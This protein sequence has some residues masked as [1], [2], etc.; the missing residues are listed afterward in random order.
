MTQRR[1]ASSIGDKSLDA[2]NPLPDTK[3]F[4]RNPR[5][6]KS[7]TNQI[8]QKVPVW[9]PFITTAGL[10][11]KGPTSLTNFRLLIHADHHLCAPHLRSG[12]FIFHQKLLAQHRI[13]S[14]IIPPLAAIHHLYTLLKSSN[15]LSK[16]SSAD[17][18]AFIFWLS[19]HKDYQ[20]LSQ[21]HRTVMNNRNIGGKFAT[22]SYTLLTEAR[23]R[24]MESEQATAG[25]KSISPQ[26]PSLSSVVQGTIE[27]M[28][29][30][31]VPTNH[32]LYGMGLRNAVREK[33]W[34]QGIDIWKR[35]KAEQKQ[36]PSPSV[37]MIAYSVECYVQ[38]G[39]V[40]EA[41]RLLG[42]ILENPVAVAQPRV[43]PE[44]VAEGG[45]PARNIIGSGGVGLETGSIN[46][47]AEN[48]KRQ[49]ESMQALIA[50]GQR[51][52]VSSSSSS[53]TAAS[54][55]VTSPDNNLEWK[56]VAYPALIEAICVGDK[57][58]DQDGATLASELAL[59]L[60]KHGYALERSRFRLLIRHIGES[61]SSEGAENFLKRW[62]E[63]SR[64]VARSR[65]LS[66]KPATEETDGIIS[67]VSTEAK[68]SHR[69]KTKRTVESTSRAL[70]EAG[71]QEIVKLA[72]AERDFERAHR[73][74][75]GMS[76]QRIPL[77]AKASEEL[78]VGLT[79]DQDF[80]SA[81][82][83][84]EKCLLDN[85]VPSIET[86]NKL[87][88]GL[89]RGDRLDESVAVFRNLTENYGVNPNI[90]TFRSL[91]NLTA[92]YGQLPMTQR[93]LTTLKTLGMKQDGELYRD[94]MRCYVR[95]ENLKGAIM[96]FENMDRDGVIHEIRH[97]NVLLEGAVR[98]ST[99]S[100]I[101]GILEIMAS[102]SI[103]P[104]PETWNILLS[105]A[106]QGKD[107][108][109]AQKLF[110]E[111]SRSVARG[112][113]D[114]EDG[115]LRASRHPVTF[116]LLINNFA[117]RHGVE[118]ALALLKGAM[119]GAY[120][121]RISLGM[122]RELMEKS[123]D[124]G[125]GV[126]GYGFYQ[127]MRRTE[128]EQNRRSKPLSHSPSA[129]GKLIVRSL[130]S[131]SQPKNPFWKITPLPSINS[132]SPSIKVPT[133]AGLC[134][135]M[136]KRL[137]QEGQYEVGKE[138]ATDL[139]LSGAE[140]DQELVA[141]AIAF[142]AKTGELEAAFGLFTKM[143]KAYN[144]EPSRGMVEVLVEAAHV[145]GLFSRSSPSST[146]RLSSRSSS[147][148]ATGTVS[149]AGQGKVGA[150]WDESTTQQWTKVLRTAMVQ[151]G[152][153]DM[154]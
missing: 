60:L 61:K 66:A 71:L 100:T 18:D 49:R 96:V 112:T 149:G 141:H 86:T 8:A 87:L 25:L 140:M 116:Q 114:I 103:S 38:I 58:K 73:I 16:L 148:P 72:T 2:N 33:N 146:S 137:D 101:I 115:S 56:T 65:P 123:L 118:P 7:T 90:E 6:R 39:D 28:K 94:L 134:R 104:N 37:A 113:S 64:S 144:V 24:T 82:S 36:L 119:D 40:A 106:F 13:P 41:T 46:S 12:R 44:S 48:S 110:M 74:F 129:S 92:A 20:T 109:L 31:N 91:M 15:H 9:T 130:L 30:V 47:R 105:G 136:M 98:Q 142:C 59:E 84:L 75:Q 50:L 26:S 85:R 62:L 34:M 124:R 43:N 81:T 151:F 17:W 125:K 35:M 52:L 77:S 1:T 42:S 127:L 70:A 78:I 76:S 143:G 89:V 4:E 19:H 135:R 122:F 117:D 3:T 154:V 80:Q 145:H 95:C 131:A 63:L 111:L 45:S 11:K 133:L 107:K 152:V 83:V 55:D 99:P 68:G 147:T 14:T 79:A 153:E 10:G 108:I 53:S 23:L 54:L 132:T 102:Q 51:T 138:L 120:P 139:I 29:I 69:S 22:S 32:A 88:R 97:I 21:L 5:T 93:I 126:V 121:S 128:Q 27:W 57:D 67:A 150:K